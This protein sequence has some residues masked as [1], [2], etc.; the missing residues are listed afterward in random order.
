[1]AA[2]ASKE[3]EGMGTTIVAAVPAP[4]SG[5]IH[6][7]HVGDSRC[8]RLRARHFEQLTEDH[9]LLNDVLESWPDVDDSALARLPRNVVTRALGMDEKLRVSIRS[10]EMVGGDRYLLCSD[11]LT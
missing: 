1:A 4:R 7:A 6:V 8:Y 11:G 10:Y 3:K 5:A 9:S 2:R